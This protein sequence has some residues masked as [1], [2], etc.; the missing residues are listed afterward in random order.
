MVAQRF[1]LLCGVFLLGVV[2]GRTTTAGRPAPA[3]GIPDSIG[4]PETVFVSVPNSTGGR[5][6]HLVRGLDIRLESPPEGFEWD[7]ESCLIRLDTEQGIWYITGKHDP[8]GE[9]R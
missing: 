6:Y 2:I 1:L 4:R 7:G 8:N 9:K 3:G 5:N